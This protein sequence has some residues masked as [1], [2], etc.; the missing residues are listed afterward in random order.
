MK[1]CATSSF[2]MMGKWQRLFALR[3]QVMLLPSAVTRTVSSHF[4]Y[5]NVVGWKNYFGI[6][7][8]S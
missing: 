8:Y 7:F 1:T 2:S 3:V 5:Y 4:G 6:L